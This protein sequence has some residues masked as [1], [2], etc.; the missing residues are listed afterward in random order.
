MGRPGAV[1]LVSSVAVVLLGA[2]PMAGATGHGGARLNRG[3]TVGA[4]AEADVCARESWIAGSVDLCDGAVVYRDYVFD[5][6]GADDPLV[7]AQ[8][9]STTGSLARP[10]GDD[11]YPEGQ[12]ATADLVDLTLELVGDRLE[13]TFE[14]NALYEPDSTIAALAIDTDHDP[15]TGGGRWGD[16]EVAS[17]G[18]E[19]LETFDEGDPDTNLI[20]GSLP[21][22]D[23]EVWRL[24][25]VTAQA[26]GTVM[27]VAFR[28]TNERTDAGSWFEDLQAAAL[29]R[30]DIDEFGHAVEVAELRGGVTRPAPLEPGYHE[31]VFVS[32]FTLPPGEGMSYEPHFGR[33]GDTG[34]LCEQEFH[35]FGPYQPYGIYVPEGPRPQGLQLALH[36]CNANHSS[37]VDQPGMQTQFGDDLNRLVVVPLGRGP[38]GFYSDISE[39]DVLEVLDDVLATYE[40]DRDRIL[41][42][43]YSMGGYG[44]Y[45]FAMLYPHLFAGMVNWVG[46]TGNAGNNSLSE[47][48]ARDAPSGAIGNLIDFVG[49]LRHIPS[50]LIYATGDELVQVHTHRAMADEFAAHD[51]VYTYYDHHNAEHLTFAV[52]DDW[53]KEAEFSAD[54][55]LVRDP[56]R[57]TYRTDESLAFPEYGIRHDRAYWLSGIEGREEGYID[58]DVLTYGCGGTVPTYDTAV[59]AG[60]GP[61]PLVWHSE[62]KFVTGEEELEPANRFEAT[63]ANLASVTVDV[64]AACLG[65]GPVA[66]SVETDGPVE[67]LLSDGRSLVL[68]DAGEH[69]GRI[70]ATSSEP[71]Q[72]GEAPPLPST[73]GGLG[74]AVLSL[75]GA[76]ILRPRRR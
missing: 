47:E 9:G 66:Y 69:E 14:L 45:R 16:L 70:P 2:P 68:D 60:M 8:T 48:P 4:S 51:V 35:F 73:G 31:R 76:L 36:G 50:V 56:N 1:A 40:V 44:A 59:D 32:D 58:L 46:F 49:N 38:I 13:V 5:D 64:E 53:A 30:G 20:T 61:A 25:A 74:A 52:R 34:S 67:I 33:H 7:A 17:R 39:A 11:R 10:A 43:G 12:E 62:S 28:G 19:V 15:S 72:P 23:S 3:G 42:G 41:A 21:A 37:L 63:F 65:D 27:N 55:T 29:A 57:V 22:P 54:L 24:Q 26:D 75:I 6:Y 71:Q 18:W